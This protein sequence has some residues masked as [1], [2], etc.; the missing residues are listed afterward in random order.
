[1]GQGPGPQ[2]GAPEALLK[3]YSGDDTLI[4][5]ITKLVADLA[6]D[7][8]DMDQEQALLIR[9]GVAGNSGGEELD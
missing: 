3:D 4:A 5:T 7:L 9:T 1:M 6:D 8:A 2:A